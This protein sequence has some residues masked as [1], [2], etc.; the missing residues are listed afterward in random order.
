M[1]SAWSPCMGAA[2][3][4]DQFWTEQLV[5]FVRKLGTLG[6]HMRQLYGIR[7]IWINCLVGHP[8]RIRTCDKLLR[9]QLL[10]PLS[11]GR[12]QLR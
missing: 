9:R 6:R 4:P 12:V 10:Y 7:G 11:Y 1:V 5:T 2:D 3:S 8:G